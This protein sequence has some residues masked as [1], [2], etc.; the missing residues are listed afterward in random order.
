MAYSRLFLDEVH[1]ECVDGEDDECGHEHMVDAAD[2][3][4]LKQVSVVT[5]ETQLTDKSIRP[6]IK[7]CLLRL[8]RQTRGYHHDPNIF[9]VV[10]KTIFFY[11]F[12]EQ[13]VKTQIN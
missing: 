11:L 5:V 7:Y 3:A 10:F 9:I 8:Q 2:M 1:E 4:D 13:K 6:K 12:Q